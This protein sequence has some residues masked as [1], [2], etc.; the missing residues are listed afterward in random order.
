MLHAIR[1]R[2]EYLKNPLGI[3]RVHPQLGWNLEGDGK[4][5]VAFQIRSAHSKQSVEDGNCFWESEIISSDRMT[6]HF[7]EPE[8]KSGERVYW[9]VRIQDEKGVFG[10]WSE[11]AFFEM[12]LLDRTDWKAQWITGDYQPEEAKRYPADEFRTEIVIPEFSKARLYI[13]ACGVYETRLNGR[14]VGE[15]VLTPGSTVYEK[16]LQYQTYDITDQLKQGKNVWDI[17]LGDGWFRGKL[18]VFGAAAVFGNRT[19]VKAQIEVTKKDGS[20]IWFVTD[21]NF[22]WCNDGKIRFND[23]KDG[24][25]IEASCHPSYKGTAKET[26]WDAE[27]CCS[28]NVNVVEKEVF[29]PTV[30]H[31]SDG[32]TIL[33]FGQNIAGYVEFSVKG[34][35]GHEVKLTMGEMLDDNGNFTLSNLVMDFDYAPDYCDD[36]RFQTIIYK[37]GSSEREKW[38]PKFCVQGFQYVKL[39]NWPEEVAPENF[40]AIAVYSDMEEIGEFHSSSE[41]MEQLVKNTLWS[42]KGNFLDVPTDCP[43]RERAAW[44]GDAQ[45]F[46]DAGCY[47]MDFTAF[48]RKWLQDVFDDQA[49]DGKI[50]NIVPKVAPHEGMNLMVEG[51]SG[52]VDA[53]ILI[54]YRYWK[55]YHDAEIIKQYYPAMKKLTDFLLSRMG[56]ESDPELDKKLP[57]HELRKYVVTTGFHFGEWNEPEVSGMDPTDPKYEEATAYLVYSLRCMAEMAEEIGNKKDA[58]YYQEVARNAKEAYRHY[59]IGDGDIVSERMCKYVRPLALDLVN[60]TEK[61]KI[62]NGLIRLVRNQEHHVGTGFLSTPFVLEVLSEAGYI[63]DAYQMLLKDAYPG[64]IYEIRQGATTIWEN[65]NGEASRNHYSNGAVCDWIFRHVC[66][67]SVDGENHFRIAPRPGGDVKQTSFT[68]QSLYGKVTCE[69]EK[70]E[71]QTSYRICIPAGCTAK[72]ELPGIVKTEEAG[73][74]QWVVKEK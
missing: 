23:M 19:C 21:Q 37:C 56:D 62:Q 35:K 10:D 22:R 14:K 70:D 32:N 3:D 47:F 49:E 67:I 16:R 26:S 61:I 53:G 65:W 69:W 24:E 48:F 9:Q 59:F 58:A 4:K 30:L 1:L 12:G 25:T 64:W 17:T 42:I 27:L 55:H 6:G 8:V 60:E 46:F 20:K 41:D 11:P 5:Q 73:I 44:T 51:S 71:K 43:T 54:P 72:I 18:G 7:Y 38:K 66:G 13:T 34:K 57:P 33:D 2:T 36:S 74:Y 29:E 68:Y 15:Q 40:R 50:Y 52:W 39:E 28:N 63:E 31:T 45:L